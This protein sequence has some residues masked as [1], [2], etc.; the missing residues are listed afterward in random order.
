MYNSFGDYRYE[1]SERIAE[2]EHAIRSPFQ[3]S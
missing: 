2:L 3:G 1:K